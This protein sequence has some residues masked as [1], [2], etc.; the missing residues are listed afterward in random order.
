MR[1]PRV[2]R[3]VQQTPRHREPFDCRRP[4]GR[5]TSIVVPATHTRP[6][7]PAFELFV[8]RRRHIVHHQRSPDHRT[9]LLSRT[10]VTPSTCC[11][12]EMSLVT[13]LPSFS[14]PSPLISSNKMSSM[15]TSGKNMS[16]IDHQVKIIHVNKN[17]A[18]Y[19]K[20]WIATGIQLTLYIS[21]NWQQMLL[22]FT[23]RYAFANSRV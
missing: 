3:T 22:I 16:H 2:P 8:P 5:T 1:T 14:L 20:H 7:K 19:V 10:A 18:Q 17:A 13:Y 4:T 21:K 12:V 6:S 23:L 15:Q 11:N 9:G